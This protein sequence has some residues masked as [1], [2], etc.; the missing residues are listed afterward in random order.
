MIK[1][2]IPGYKK[3]EALHCTKIRRTEQR[4]G[5]DVHAG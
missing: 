1:T 5:V 4:P 3:I 2:D